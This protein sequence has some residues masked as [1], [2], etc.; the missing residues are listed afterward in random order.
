MQ[1]TSANH[2]KP[3]L[4]FVYIQYSLERTAYICNRSLRE[5][6]HSYTYY[7]WLTNQNKFT[8][9]EAAGMMQKKRKKK[10]FVLIHLRCFM[11]F[12]FAAN[13]KWQSHHIGWPLCLKKPQSLPCGIL[14]RSQI[15][16]TN[17]CEFLCVDRPHPCKPRITVSYLIKVYILWNM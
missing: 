15:H 9:S 3:K 16:K 17:C 5:A 12:R 13:I 7:I 10:H 4:C 2:H 1:R 8:M 6:I 14:A 11:R